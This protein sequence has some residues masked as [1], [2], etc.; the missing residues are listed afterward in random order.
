MTG[1]ICRDRTGGGRRGH[2]DPDK[3]KASRSGGSGG[4]GGE[5]SG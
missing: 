4:R 5:M 3:V 2:I 1:G